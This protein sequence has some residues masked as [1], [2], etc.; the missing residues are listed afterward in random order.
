M[1]ARYVAAVHILVLTASG[2]EL[3][4]CPWAEDA[5]HT[6][7]HFLAAEAADC[8]SIVLQ[9]RLWALGSAATWTGERDFHTRF[10]TIDKP[11]AHAP[12]QCAKT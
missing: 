8:V 10:P 12:E 4:Q 5:L 11:K 2:P 9:Q 7:V 6:L 3:V 1:R